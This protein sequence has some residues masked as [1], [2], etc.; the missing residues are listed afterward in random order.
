MLQYFHKIFDF[1]CKIPLFERAKR[2]FLPDLK[3]KNGMEWTN[4]ECH[5]TPSPSPFT[6]PPLSLLPHALSSFL[7]SKWPWPI[8]DDV[9]P[10]TCIRW[11]SRLRGP[12]NLGTQG[13]KAPDAAMASKGRSLGLSLTWLCH[14]FGWRWAPFKCVGGVANLPRR[15]QAWSTQWWLEVHRKT[16]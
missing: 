11:W 9:G 2:R 14:R 8:N 3:K 10:S 13:D 16:H 6:F 5:L 7:S 1:F 4:E 12:R 15:W